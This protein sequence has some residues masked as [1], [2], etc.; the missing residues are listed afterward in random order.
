M[1]IARTIIKPVIIIALL[2]TSQL[3]QALSQGPYE[4][5]T[6]FGGFFLQ[7]TQPINFCKDNPHT[8]YAIQDLL[9]DPPGY[10]FQWYVKKFDWGLDEWVTSTVPGATHN[11]IQLIKMPPIISVWLIR[12]VAV[13]IIQI[14]S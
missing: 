14:L 12:M 13:P 8:I 6:M 5:S 7:M 1:K 11:T 3:N 2:L 10:S 9:P 4:Y